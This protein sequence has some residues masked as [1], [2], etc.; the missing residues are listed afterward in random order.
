MQIAANAIASEL[1]KKVVLKSASPACSTSDHKL[2]RRV[3]HVVED[4]VTAIMVTGCLPKGA[5]KSPKYR[6]A[7]K[8]DVAK[9]GRAQAVRKLHR[10]R[11]GC[12]GPGRLL[13]ASPLRRFPSD[14]PWSTPPHGKQLN[15]HRRVFKRD[16]ANGP[17]VDDHLETKTRPQCRSSGASAQTT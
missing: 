6:V 14:Q 4:A 5:S 10:V 15:V 17:L 9:K 12:R 8:R 1:S 3:H 7:T 11:K 2:R 13:P 16:V